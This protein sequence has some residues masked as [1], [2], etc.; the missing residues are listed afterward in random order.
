MPR[1]AL[2]EDDDIMLSL[3]QTLLQLEGFEVVP[4]PSSSA[5][6]EII[7]AIRL[8]KPSAVLM[9]VHLRR[10]N[11]INLLRALRQDDQLQDTQVIMS[12]GL[13]YSVECLKEGANGFLLKP[14]MPDDLIH[15]VKKTLGT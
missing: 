14:Y 8:E 10:A 2:I 12:S 13:D 9:D 11:G 1:I 6:D 4:I 15:E 7:A 5:P 3:L